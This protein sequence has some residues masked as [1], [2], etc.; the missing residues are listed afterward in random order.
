VI[1]NDKTKILV[2][3]FIWDLI[4]NY[5]I[6][7]GKYPKIDINQ[8]S[9]LLHRYVYYCLYHRSPRPGY[10]VDHVYG[11]TLDITIEN[12]REFTNGENN[13]NCKKIDNCTSKFHG[14]SYIKA[15]DK[16]QCE[17]YVNNKTINYRYNNE[18]HAA[19]HYNLLIKQ[20]KLEYCSPLNN[21]KKPDDFILKINQPKTRTLPECI[22]EKKGGFCYRILD[23]YSSPFN[24]IEEALDALQKKRNEKIQAKILEIESLP[25]LRN[26][27][28]QAIIHL[29][30]TNKKGVTKQFTISVDSHKYHELL[31][32]GLSM[33]KDYVHISKINMSLSRYLTNC[34]DKKKVVDHRDCNKLNYQMNNLRIITTR[35]NS[36]NRLAMPD[37]TSKYVGVSKSHDSWASSI[38]GKMIGHYSTEYEAVTIRDMKA[39]ELNLA[40]A[41]YKINLPA[42]LQMNLF[43]KA[44]N[45]DNF[46]LDYL[47]YQD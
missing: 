26:D 7:A 41:L 27:Q 16:W 37:S 29:S 28:G 47:F 45:E 31:T 19:Y 36:Q 30:T 14:V 1:L 44:M 34:T 3:D 22:H 9:Y 46:Q 20:Y 4:K 10:V 39:Y 32:L 11:D 40:G 35:Q 18:L 43:I 6:T 8:K 15:R 2:N 33:R 17:L 24:T 25:I 42:E 21:I 13:R 38:G 5:Q 12:L 23:T